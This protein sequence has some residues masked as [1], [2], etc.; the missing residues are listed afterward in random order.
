LLKAK[1]LRQSE[2]SVGFGEHATAMLRVTYSAEGKPPRTVWIDKAKATRE[3]VR[4][5]ILADFNRTFGG[6]ETE[7]ELT[8]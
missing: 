7:V 3:N 6:K 4:A 5:M 2:I 8:E 1:L